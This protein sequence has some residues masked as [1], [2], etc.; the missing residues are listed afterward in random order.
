[1]VK[2]Q[3]DCGLCMYSVHA[4]LACD[5]RLINSYSFVSIVYD[6]VFMSI[7]VVKTSLNK[8]FQYFAWH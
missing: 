4:S 7:K 6:N 2:L 8:Y 3:V 5:L 1:M